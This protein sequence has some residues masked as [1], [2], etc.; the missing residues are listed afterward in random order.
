MQ[1]QTVP[2]NAVNWA[3]DSAPTWVPDNSPFLNSISVGMPR[4]PY[5]AAVSRLASTSTLQTFNR[6]SYSSAIS[7]STGAI[8]LHGPHQLAQKST[9]T[10]SLASKTSALKLASLT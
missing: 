4:T 1:V 9:R 8:I 7:S 5:C 6:P 10:G 2:T 3:F